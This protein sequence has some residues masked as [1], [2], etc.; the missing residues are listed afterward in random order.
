MRRI[1]I[2]DDDAILLQT[3]EI[4]LKNDYDVVTFEEVDPAIDYMKENK[5]DLL[6]LDIRMPEISGIMAFDMI[7]QIEYGEEIPVVFI[8]GYSDKRTVAECIEKGASNYLLKPVKK[9]ILIETIE[10]TLK[11]SS[12]P[13]V[14]SD[15]PILLMVTRQQETKDLAKSLNGEYFVVTVSNVISAAEFAKKNKPE[16][17]LV[18]YELPVYNGVQTV[19]KI[20]NVA[21]E[22]KFGTVI[23]YQELDDEKKEE[24]ANAGV[25]C[26]KRPLKLDLLKNRLEEARRAVINSREE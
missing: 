12:I 25:L 11:T 23:T 14:T 26:L 1:M 2:I 22:P 10:S 15:K 4:F 16:V 24:A 6:F 18:D 7:K 13:V 9:E 8:S 21:L 20:Q 5:V 19:G 17:L 3:L